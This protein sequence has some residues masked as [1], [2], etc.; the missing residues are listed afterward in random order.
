MR[1]RY[2]AYALGL[3]EYIIRTTHPGN[4][5]AA[6]PE[7]Q[8]KKEIEEFCRI[9]TFKGL[10]ILEDQEGETISTVTFKAF[11]SQAGKDFS[12]A[13][14]STFEKVNGHWLYL[15]GEY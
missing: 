1:S 4:P 2:S 10:H 15:K 3:V 12:F 6:K 9:T 13:E 8:R 5:E 14:K 11:L 7:A